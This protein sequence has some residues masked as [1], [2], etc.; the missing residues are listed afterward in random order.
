M[1]VPEVDEMAED[2]SVSIKESGNSE[3]QETTG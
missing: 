2:G 3:N 1:N